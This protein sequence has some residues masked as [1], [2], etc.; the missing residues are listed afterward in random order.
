MENSMERISESYENHG[1]NEGTLFREPMSRALRPERLKTC[2]KGAELAVT[3]ALQNVSPNQE[4]VRLVASS[5]ENGTVVMSESRRG[6]P[7]V[8]Q[9]T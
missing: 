6:R 9:L 3:E 4:F 2:F 1:W 8:R 5:S 7:I